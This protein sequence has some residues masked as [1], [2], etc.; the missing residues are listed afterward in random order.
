MCVLWLLLLLLLLLIVV[1]VVVVALW[2]RGEHLNQHPFDGLTG[3]QMMQN[4]N[5]RVNQAFS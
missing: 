4:C 1:V 5:G 2:R 3:L